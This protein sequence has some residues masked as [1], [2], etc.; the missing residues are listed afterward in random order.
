[1]MSATDF[2]TKIQIVEDMLSLWTVEKILD[3]GCGQ[4]NYA[5]HLQDK[6]FSVLG[7]EY[8]QVC[9]DKYL[10]DIPHICDSIVE[11]V[12]KPIEPF[13]VVI[14]IDVL[15]HLNYEDIPS[16]LEGF[17]KI[18][19]YAI[20]GIANHSDIQDGEELHIIQQP[21]I[22]WIEQLLPYYKNFSV[23][24]EMYDGRFFFLQVWK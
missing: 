13:D 8:S 5:R 6:G 1:M 15:E 4:G 24:A 20:L 7:L 9:C 12:K 16:V 3:V 10:T 18:A 11:Y 14:C 22:W 2:N 21:V 23:K 17:S 19:D